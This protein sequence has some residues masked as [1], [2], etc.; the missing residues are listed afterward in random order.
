MAGKKRWALIL[1]ILTFSAM[2]GWYF[3]IRMKPVPAR[4]TRILCMGDS[5]TSSR[6][7]DYTTTL[8][9]RFETFDPT[10][11]VHTAARPGNTSGE[12][13][14]WLKGSDILSRVNP[15]LVVLMLGTNDTRVDSDH[16]P[17]QRFSRQMEAILAHIF[18]HR[19]PDTSRPRVILSSIPPIIRPDLPVFSEESRERV[20]K[21]INPA[22][23]ELA[24]KHDLRLVDAHHFF[25][26]NPEL[27]PGVHPSTAGY[28]GLGNLIFHHLKEIVAPTNSSL[29]ERI[30][31]G[32][33]G[34]IAFESDRG[35]NFDIFLIN[36]AGVRPLTRHPGH[37]GH[38]AFSPD[39]QRLVFESDRS[40][41]FEIHISDSNQSIRRLFP[42]PTQDRAPFWT[43]DGQYIYFARRIKGREQVFRYRF[44][45]KVTERITHSNRRTG[46]PCVSPDGRTLMVT[47][48]RLRGWNLFTINLDTGVET[49]FS[50][51]YAGC[52]AR[53]A[54]SGKQ[55][56]FVSHKFDHRGDIILTPAHR[57][58]PQRLTLDNDH[59]D[60]YPSFSPDDR[61][62]VYASGPQLKGGDYNLRIIEIP[63]GRTWTITRHP[64][65]DI[66]PFWG[67]R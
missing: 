52:R 43:A 62:L 49:L 39:G 40:G 33:P 41:R 23:R 35:G 7:G 13:L 47:A 27:L 1:V 28:K 17:T 8:A 14:H 10:V 42:S 54:N 63:S 22:I 30:P 53:Y 21:E 48:H 11:T 60:Y 50:P 64:A 19:N 31:E 56:A 29:E 46:I 5:I 59:H 44:R 58:S 15:D 4:N 18:A 34:T 67:V 2:A 12:Y 45:G 32:I 3:F 61:F 55:V 65:T 36:R 26:R 20:E 37:D 9:S 16:T 6:Y 25:S 24:R 51:G 38:P 66:K 57:F